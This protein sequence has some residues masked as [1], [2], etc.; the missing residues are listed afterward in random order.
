MRIEETKRAFVVGV[1]ID[2]FG[3]QRPVFDI[4]RNCVALLPWIP[5]KKSRCSYV[6][7]LL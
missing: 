2:V 6:Y 7:Y 1:G 3:R 4:A 5:S